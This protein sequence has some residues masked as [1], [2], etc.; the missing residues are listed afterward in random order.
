MEACSMSKPLF[1][2]LLLK[3][4]QQDRFELDRIGLNKF[5]GAG[6]TDTI[7]SRPDE[8]SIGDQRE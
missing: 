2:Y 4:V 5:I 7:T 6:T 1:A 3:L 8:S